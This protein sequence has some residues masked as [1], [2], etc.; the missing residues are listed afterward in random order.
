MRMPV[1]VLSAEE[2]ASLP[3]VGAPFAPRQQPAA[4]AAQPERSGSPFSPDF[5]APMETLQLHTIDV[6]SHGVSRSAAAGDERARK[7][8]IARMMD[9]LL[10]HAP[11]AFVCCTADQ[12]Q[13]TQPPCD[14]VAG[15]GAKPLS[16]TFASAGVT[17]MLG[18]QPEALCGQSL[19]ELLHPDDCLSTAAAMAPLLDGRTTCMYLMRRVR[20]AHD[21]AYFWVHMQM[22]RA[23]DTIY[24]VWR[25]ATRHT[26][27][28][29]ALREYL[30]AMSHD[31]RTP[32]HSIVSASQ[33]LASRESV[34]GD[35]EA[36][37]LVQAIRSSGA[38]MLGVIGNVLGLRDI[39]ADA[40]SAA[41]QHHAGEA[42]RLS[43]KPA[44]FNP[45]AL[46]E[47]ALAT[48]SLAE[49]HPQAVQ[50]E[51]QAAL[52][53]ALDG[54]VDALTQM[55][56]NMLLWAMRAS[57]D[58]PLLLHVRC[59]E[60]HA[61]AESSAS[62]EAACA[63]APLHGKPGELIVEVCVPG[64]TLSQEERDRM[65]SVRVLYLRLLCIAPAVV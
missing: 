17:R 22:S 58:Q 8:V 16:I 31:L 23:G 27:T 25:D 46:V 47:S 59:S 62:H 52:P 61:T 64:A 51:Q 5:T 56:T 28:Q 18:W 26:H 15:G 20:C 38:L 53:P 13:Q 21:G 10:K 7:E 14:F 55:L 65:F 44:T 6:L 60:P 24:G 48:C 54:D 19:F 41:S 49:G 36:A 9:V 30:D 1:H 63:D 3:A 37:F 29:A 2:S 12:Q 43:M 57:G 50:W 34:A 33:L 4:A 40:G 42:M 11:D 35:A 39:D 45:A 32:A